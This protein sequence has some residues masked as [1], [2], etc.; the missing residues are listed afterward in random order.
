MAL[1]AIASSDGVII[2]GR[3]DRPGTFH[4]Y[5]FDGNGA[6]TFLEQRSIPRRPRCEHLPLIPQAAALLLADVCVI[7][8]AS[9]PK[10]TALFLRTRGIMAFAVQGEVGLALEAYSR[11]GRLLDNLFAHVR[12]RFRHATHHRNPSEER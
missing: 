8:A 4:I 5:R 2:D 1:V 10:E 9:V 3:L 7:L 6:G 11:R 12:G